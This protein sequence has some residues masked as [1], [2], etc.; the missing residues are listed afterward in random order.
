LPKHYE[1]VP[2]FFGFSLAPL[3]PGAAKEPVR[4]AKK[5]S[6]R[7]GLISQ[8]RPLDQACSGYPQGNEVD[9]EQ[10][11]NAVIVIE[12]DSVPARI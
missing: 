7:G 2:G 12:A 11:G 3:F 9:L 1:K 6:G 8:Q 10:A 4:V 5:G